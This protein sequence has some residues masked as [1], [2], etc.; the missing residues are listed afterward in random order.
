[1]RKYTLIASL[2]LSIALLVTGCSESKVSQ[3]KRLIKVV[4]QGTSLIENNKGTQVTTSLRLSEDLQGVTK[5]LQQLKL[6]DP[7]LQKYQ[8]S[9]ATIFGDLSQAIAKA[10]KALGATK[11]AEASN[12][13]RKKIQNARQDIESIL[14]TAAETAGKES[15]TFGN[16]L[17]NYCSQS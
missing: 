2:S 8:T 13:G 10:G 6:T 16:Q 1:V 3:C 14:T 11:N 5:S 9:F 7:E 15:D 4:N 12:D 17:N